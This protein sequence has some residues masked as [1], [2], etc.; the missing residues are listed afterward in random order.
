MPTRS[1]KRPVVLI[2]RDGWG[3][4]PHPEHASFNA[5]DK[6]STPVADRLLRDYPSAPIATSGEDVGLPAGTMGNS[7]VGHQ[8]LGAGRIVDQESVRITKAIRTGAIFENEAL[9][10]AVDATDDRGG[11]VHLLCIASDAGVH[12]LL[13][14]LY[15]LAELCR[16]RNAAKV[17]IHLFTDGRDTGPFTGRGYVQ[18]VIDRCAEIGAGEVATLVGRYWA[19]DRDNRWERVRRAYDA[20]TGRGDAP[21]HFPDAVAAI[22]DHYDR[23]ENPALK[24]DEFVTPRT[25]ATRGSDDGAGSRIRSGDCVLFVNYRGDRPRELVR[26]FRMPTFYG[27]VAPSPDTGEP[28]F[29][30]GERL[31]L[32]FVTLTAYQEALNELVDVAFPKPPKMEDI[33][34]AYLARL[35]FRQFR[36]AETE[37]FPHVTFFF[38]DY[39]EEPFDGESRGMAQSPR[40]ATYD[41]RPA[42]SARAVADH[43]LGR[44]RAPD[45]EDFIL[46]YFANTDLVGHTGVLAA[47]VDAAEAVDTLV[48]EIVDATLERGGALVVTADHGNAEQMW[49]PTTEAPHTAHT[50]Y[51]VDCIVV[52]ADGATELRP[53]GRLADVFPTVL[54]LMGLERPEAMTGRSLLE[55]GP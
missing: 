52:G 28:G 4:N 23:P 10:S 18:Q 44:L 17:Y 3:R 22:Q 35:G 48:G 50:L 37:K 51:D 32:D 46:V 30:R 33:G 25:V 42:M 19:M 31:D 54:E 16:R 11:A 36:S 8:N 47:A 27:E 49:D 53:G 15:A 43:V 1:A 29:D 45:C 55:T 2:I 9:T 40:V 7:E 26:A 6:A 14:H 41:R 38:N 12:G 34:G 20:L 39:R 21:P 5:I 13:D 24:G